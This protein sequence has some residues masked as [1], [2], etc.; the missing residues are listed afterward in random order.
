MRDAKVKIVTNRLQLD[1]AP[2]P[3]VQFL[4]IFITASK[5]MF[6]VVAICYTGCCKTNLWYTC[7]AGRFRTR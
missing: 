4:V 5:L 3:Q 1:E 6:K 2:S 7:T